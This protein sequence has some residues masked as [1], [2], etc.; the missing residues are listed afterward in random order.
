M[1]KPYYFIVL[2]SLSRHKAAYHHALKDLINDFRDIQVQRGINIWN[3]YYPITTV[4]KIE[5]S[6]DIIY[7][8]SGKG[9][10]R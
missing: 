9:I 6:C 1:S 8:T 4:V 5:V 10:N 3:Y 7:V 2:L